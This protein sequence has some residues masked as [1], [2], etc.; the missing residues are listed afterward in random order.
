MKKQYQAD[1]ALLGVT[2]AWGVS[3]ILTKNSLATLET[4]NFLGIRFL[5]AAI[6]SALFFYKRFMKLDRATLKY[7]IFI[8]IIMFSGYAAQTIGLNYT[9]ASKS[10]F[11]TGFSVVIVP[12]FSAIVLKKIPRFSSVIGVIAA[13]IGLGLLTLDATLQLNIGD[14]YTLIGAFCF[15]F[16]IITVGKYAVQVDSINLAILQIGVVGILSTVVS[17]IFETPI[18]PTDEGAWFSILFLSFVCTSGA[19]IVQNAVQ[20]YT[21]T[22]HTAL[23]FTGEPVFSAIFAYFLLGEVMNAR[24]IFGSILIVAGMLVA[25]LDID[26]SFLK[27]G[28]KEALREQ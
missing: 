16:H 13:I 2:L 21:T 14:F 19:F 4:F 10:G 1:L 8:G 17:V 24:G 12:I 3:F 26:L 11:I 22:T 9:T 20:K 25:E 7:G 15:A 27:S 18:L 23:I 6:A 28:K 5:I